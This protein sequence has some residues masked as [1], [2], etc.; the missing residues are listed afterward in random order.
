MKDERFDVFEQCPTGDAGFVHVTRVVCVTPPPSSQS[1]QN[2]SSDIRL[3]SERVLWW[4]FR[5]PSVPPMETSLIK[6]L[7]KSLLDN[8]KD[9]NTTVRG[10]SEHT[11]VNLLGLRQGEE[12]MQVSLWAQEGCLKVGVMEDENIASDFSFISP[13]SHVR[14]LLPFWTLQVTNYCQ[15]VTAGR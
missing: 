8:T 11:I 2:Q 7:L 6:P 14:V 5:D 4:V 1:L 12:T 15:S 9:K 3:V 13:F 10:Q